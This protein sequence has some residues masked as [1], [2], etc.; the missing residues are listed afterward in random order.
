MGNPLVTIPF[1]TE[2]LHIA[3]VFSSVHPYIV[4]PVVPPKS[5]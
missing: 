5:V 3:D 1:V 2:N 4:N